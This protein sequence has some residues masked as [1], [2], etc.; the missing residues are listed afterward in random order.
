MAEVITFGPFTRSVSSVEAHLAPAEC[1]ATGSQNYLVDPVAG[2]AFKRS[3]VTNA[4]GD[5][6]DIVTGRCTAGLLESTPEYVPCRLRSFKSDALADGALGGYPTPSV[7]YRREASSTSWPTVDDGVFGTDYVRRASTNYTLLSEFG[8]TAYPTGGGAHGSEIKYKV[9][10]FW[11]ESGEG[12]YS[13]GATEFTRRFV[14]SGSWDTMDAGRWRYYPNLRGTPLRWDGGCNDSFASVANSIRVTPTGPMPPAWMPTLATGTSVAAAGLAAAGGTAVYPWAEGDSFY[15]SVI[16]QF[17]DGSYSAP[18]IPRSPNATLTSGY[19]WKVLGTPAATPANYYKTVEWTNIPIGPAGTTARVL[20]RTRKQAQTSATGLVTVDISDLRV[21]GV[22]KNNT[23]KSFSDSLADDDG[24][25]L[26]E[27]VVRF[28]TIVPPRARYIGTGDNRCLVGYTLPNPCAIQL[29]IAGISAD[30]D[31]NLDES[32]T[33]ISGTTSALYRVT[34]SALELI[35]ASAGAALATTSI[36]LSSTKT[37]QEVVDEVNATVR[38]A[39]HGQFRAQLC[40]GV[41]PTA[42]SNGLCPTVQDVA[43]CTATGT[44]LANGGVGFAAIPLG[45]KCYAAAGMTAGTYVVS[46]TATTITLSAASTTAAATVTFYADC[47]DEACVT[48]AGSKGWIRVFGPS[49]PPGFVYFKRS[50]MA[51]YDRPAKDRLY[52]T[53]SSPG[54]ASTGVSLAP[55]LWVASNRRDGVNSPGQVMGIVDIQGAAVIAYRKRIALFIN[56]RGSNT[57]ED[58]DCRVQ[59][60]NDSRGCVSP[61]S[62][63]SVNGCAVYATN[64]GLVATDKSKREILLTADEYQPI[65]AKGNM[66]FEFPK[67]VAAAASDSPDCWMAGAQWGN[68]LVYAY[69]LSASS[70]GFSVYDFSLGTDASGLES[71]ANPD[72]RRPYGWSATCR[73]QSGASTA[74]GPRALGAVSASDGLRLYGAINDN[75]GAADGRVDQLFTGSDDNSFAVSASLVSKTVVASQGTRLSAQNMTVLSKM[76]A[77]PGSV[78]V[79]RASGSTSAYTLTDATGS[80]YKRDEIELTQAARS[81]AEFCTVQLDDTGATVG[82]LLW[83]VDVEVE[84]LPTV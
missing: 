13:R 54:A 34:A 83:R 33:G 78:T 56:E 1:I 65:R 74:M 4:T 2:G 17:E 48:T 8:S 60:I 30:Y 79:T 55:N 38:D 35:V 61:W 70:Y 22:L 20:L 63:V 68:R 39:T 73:M 41:D 7:L 75:N 24:L 69:R 64:V 36:A 51:G 3:G 6:I 72:S 12:G 14:A 52:F 10:P 29:T 81:P 42:A 37:L 66:A 23:Q 50:A 28:D 84:V 5:N 31:M 15:Y 9:A 11:Y 44:S 27:D 49:Y 25:L 57:A 47:G 18:V 53:S 45:A 77:T 32:A 16:F 67:C 58:F 80:D 40:S 76:T 26:N 43:T 21:C 46:K 59:T 82:G 19:G 71:L 62:V